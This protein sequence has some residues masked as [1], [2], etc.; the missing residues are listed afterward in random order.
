MLVVLNDNEMSI[1]PNVGALS[2]WFSKKFASRTYNRWRH[3]VKDFLA[4]L[5]KGAEA[6]EVIRHGI[7]ATKALV[8]PGILFEGLGFHYVGPVDGHDVTGLVEALA[9]A[10][11]ASTRRCSSTR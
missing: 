2:E 3:S 9:E 1:S 4:K 8:T 11:D 10:R 7:N 5:P 6:I